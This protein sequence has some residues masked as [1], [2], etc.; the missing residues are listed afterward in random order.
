MPTL[1]EIGG[2][3]D[4]LADGAR[5]AAQEIQRMEERVNSLS[6]TTRSVAEQQNTLMQM[7]TQSMSGMQNQL[8]T[9]IQTMQSFNSTTS[10]G[11]QQIERTSVDINQMFEVYK[12]MGIEVENLDLN[13]KTLTFTE[14]EYNKVVKLG[15]EYNTQRISAYEQLSRKYSAM[16]ILIN[17][18]T[19]AERENTAEGRNLVAQAREIY[20][21]MNLLQQSTGK[22]QLQVGD[23][24]KAM[25]GL[26]IATQQVIREMPVLA[27]SA[28]MFVMAISNNIPILLDNIKAV[29]AS[30]QAAKAMKEDLLAQAEAAR[31]AGHD[32]EAESKMAEAN[33]IKVQSAAKGLLKSIMSWQTLI[34]LLL[35][36]LPRIIK[37]IQD[38][39]KAIDQQNG[40]MIEA[41][42][43][44]KM[45]A[46]AM[47]AGN[48]AV[49]DSITE[50][51]VYNDIATDTN[52]TW[53]D[54]IKVAETMRQKW[55]DELGSLSAEEI[56]LG[57]AQTAVDNL[58]ES[59]IRQA[60]ARA[61]L[62]EITRL[63]K[64]KYDLEQKQQELAQ[65]RIEEEEKLQQLQLSRQQTASMQQWT[66]SAPTQ[67]NTFGGASLLGADVM[68]GS[69]EKAIEKVDEEI[70][71]TDESIQN[72]GETIQKLKDRITADGLVEIFLGKGGGKKAKDKLA[73]LGDYYFDWLESIYKLNTN[74][75]QREY[76]LL[77]LQYQ[78][79]IK[80]AEDRLAKERETGQLSAE[81]EE[82]QLKI[83]ENLREQ[84]GRALWNL[85][86]KFDNDIR[87]ERFDNA[88][89][90]LND[91]KTILDNETREKYQNK[92]LEKRQLLQN[93]IDYWIQ[94][95]NILKSYG[96]L[97]VEEYAK[98]MSNINKLTQE[99]EEEVPETLLGWLGFAT[100]TD[101]TK[102]QEK[103]LKKMYSTAIQYMKEWMDARM[104]MAQVAVDAAEKETEAARKVLEYEME[105]RANGYASSVDLARK[106]Y[107]EKMEL[108]RKA[109]A[110][111]QKMQK[112]QDQINTATQISS[113][114][115]ATAELWAS[116]AS[117]GPLA[118]ALA[119]AATA[120]MWTSFIAAKA[121]AASLAKKKT[122]GEGTVELL[123]GGSHASGHDIDMGTDKNGNQRRAE[124]GEF[125]AIINKRN[126]AKYR[127]VIPDVIRSFNDGSFAEKYQRANAVM[128]SYAVGMMGCTDVSS[129]ERDVAAIRK[130]GDTTRY[131]DGHGNMIIRYKN[132]TRK[133]LS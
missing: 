9:L 52:R 81:Q 86:L 1:S 109:L 53:E 6:R 69:Q 10:Q 26:N 111:Q 72:I 80:A 91:E 101:F 58:T 40:S 92:T 90:S 119:V 44:E 78:R 18:M 73:N 47:K 74:E 75:R 29:K 97:T 129:L 22:Y 85:M 54:R 110:E 102:K 63:T 14:R 71:N 70:K 34:V 16:K 95:L 77:D 96:K 124:G 66:S 127:K 57:K 25:T 99:K 89:K 2:F 61:Y 60:E 118:V 62:E 24:S 59:L 56:A 23:Y 98:I 49:V 35:S 7:L 122:Y 28:Q 100:N 114:V 12:K 79:Q 33:A 107:E 19:Q 83:I 3:I 11:R 123:E 126:S 51:N 115:T 121:Q 30:S 64:E 32:L 103:N 37:N 43:L 106:E 36:V 84:H 65:K 48:S 55:E 27:Q 82:Y 113:L 130:Q 39:K 132:V 21:Q 94:Y 88:I 131:L 93:E 105:A 17:N 20:Q 42:S 13:L 117:T 5:N 112:L 133:I 76:Q 46:D 41:I 4:P 116:M 68:I 50:L 8:G 15:E 31:I 38:K 104:E 120:A 87:E 128:A 45:W 67:F 108:Q 125:F